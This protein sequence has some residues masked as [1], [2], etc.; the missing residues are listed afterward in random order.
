MEGD[1]T[2]DFDEWM[3]LAKNNPQQF[4]RRRQAMIDKL[5]RSRALET[6]RRLRGLQ[7][8]IDLERKRCRT[9]LAACVRL[10]EMLMDQFSNQ[11]A[12]I[13]TGELPT[14]AVQEPS[15]ADGPARILPFKPRRG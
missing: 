5:I 15:S 7:F 3:Q 8:R 9:P 2:F 13:L 4:E 6:Q 10:N 11:L 14:P 12:P 1:L